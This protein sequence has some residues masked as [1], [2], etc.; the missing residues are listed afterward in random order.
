[1]WGHGCH[2]TLNLYGLGPTGNPNKNLTKGPTRCGAR[3]WLGHFVRSGNC[4]FTEFECHETR[5]LTPKANVHKLGRSGQAWSQDI[6]TRA[7][8]EKWYITNLKSDS[9]TVR[10]PK[11]PSGKTCCAFSL[12]SLILVH[13]LRGRSVYGAVFV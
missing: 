10:D 1:M 3:K 2:Q 13:G 11:I 5:K 9:G 8:L 6:S 7:R 4:G 12:Q